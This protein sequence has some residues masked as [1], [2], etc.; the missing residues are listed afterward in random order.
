LPGRLT[1]K[2]DRESPIPYYAQLKDG[3]RAQIESGNWRPGDLLPGEAELCRQFDV[4]RTVVRQALKELTYEGLVVRRKGKGTF[5]ASPKFTESHI[6][7]LSGFFKDM[8]DLGH[9]PFSQVLRQEI[10]PADPVVAERLGLKTGAPV[11]QIDRLRFV[12]DD[13]LVLVTTY[14]PYQLCPQLV[15]ADLTHR[16]LYEFLETVCGLKLARGRRTIEAV[17]ADEYQAGLL[18]IEPGAPLILLDS[19]S[20]LEDD[21]PIEYYKALHRGDRSRFE[22][23]LIRSPEKAAQAHALPRGSGF[24]V[25]PGP[26][27]G[28]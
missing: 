27:E 7:E 26:R 16:S 25:A 28:G 2:V 5:V 15:E 8:L 1:K 6:Q 20:Y 10:I 23:E 22:V 11:V 17:A 9:T 18:R 21:T 4:S 12:E 14:L 19:V 24:V 13:P 3:L